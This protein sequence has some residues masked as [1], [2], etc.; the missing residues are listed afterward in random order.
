MMKVRCR[1]LHAFMGVA[2]STSAAGVVVRDVERK[3]PWSPTA[4]GIWMPVPHLSLI[5]VRADD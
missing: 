4:V 1:F 5:E 3:P 2:S